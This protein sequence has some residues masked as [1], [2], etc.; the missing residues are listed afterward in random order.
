MQCA[1]WDIFHHWKVFSYHK[2]LQPFWYLVFSCQATPNCHFRVKVDMLQFISSKQLSGLLTE[3]NPTRLNNY[4][5]NCSLLIKPKNA[6]YQ[7]SCKSYSSEINSFY[8]VKCRNVK[9]ILIWLNNS[10]NSI[11]NRS[12]R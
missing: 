11:E 8:F 9:I 2:S 6:K 7:N 4:S 1:N 12:V 10:Q 3:Q 5:N